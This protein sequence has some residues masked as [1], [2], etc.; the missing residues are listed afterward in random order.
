MKKSTLFF[1]LILL[2]AC[3]KAQVTEIAAAAQVKKGKVILRWAA[4]STTWKEANLKGY[5][6]ERISQSK[7]AENSPDSIKFK[8]STLAFCSPWSQDDERWTSLL[9]RNK[10]A[11]FLHGTLYSRK[12]NESNEGM[13]HGLLMKSCDLYKDLALAAGLY[14]IDST[15]HE[16]ETYVY[17]ISTG[18]RKVIVQVNTK[19]VSEITKLEP[20]S[21]LFSDRKAVLRFVSK[22]RKD[23]SGYWIE[24]S[25]DSTNFK[26]VNRSPFIHTVNPKE[27]ESKESLFADS[28]PENNKMYY[29]RIAGISLFGETSVYSN[30]VSGMGKT[31]FKEYPLIDSTEVIKNSSVLIK[32]GMPGGFDS[33]LLKGFAVLRSEKTEGPFLSLTSTLTPNTNSFRDKKPL[34]TN[35][36]K[37][38]AISIYNDSSFSLT[39]Y[40]SLVDET[41]PA[42]PT[43]LIG[44]IDSSGAVKIS[45]SPN[46][47]K[48]LLGYRVYRSNSL[49]EQPFELTKKLLT[50][51]TFTDNVSLNTL[52]R[53]VYYTLRAVD[54]NHNNSDYA[55]YC[56]LIRPD[57]IAP[58]AITFS[59]VSP[60][61]SAIVLRWNNSNSNDVKKYKLWRKENNAAWKLMRE[62]AFSEKRNSISDTV[63]LAGN[64]YQ[65]K[66]E[67]VDESGNISFTESHAV[68]YKPTFVAAI[69]TFKAKVDLAKRI[70]ELN[71]SYDNSN[72]YNYTIYKA[73]AGEALRIYKTVNGSLNSFTDKELYPGNKYTY[74]IRASLQSGSETKL[75]GVITVEF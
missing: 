7:H 10:S 5:K 47:E 63:L 27:K 9:E 20:I 12:K 25:E 69:K 31:A 62:W 29:Y 26:A 42:T 37:I 40:A 34:E 18:T 13:A 23:L 4:N 33:K 51:T 6:I 15:I 8:N 58:I 70:I 53:E 2:T 55:I 59:L 35:Y 52:T 3:L 1:I 45:W 54:K 14:Y 60:N 66:I 65:Y 57:K 46:T 48:D 50:T 43:G 19:Q 71:W 22:D 21:A 75:S 68:L 49:Y 64:T 56:K 74:A 36:Y 24:R 28:L 17:R 30:V 16:N 44:A 32:F 72:V 61:D 73:K 11:A 39:T 38:C 67:V 41:P